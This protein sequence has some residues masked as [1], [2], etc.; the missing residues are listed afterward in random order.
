MRLSTRQEGVFAGEA[1]RINNYISALICCAP[2]Y[3]NAAGYN[4]SLI[5]AVRLTLQQNYSIAVAKQQIAASEGLAL[6]AKSAFDMQLQAGVNRQHSYSPTL[7]PATNDLTLLPSDATN[8]TLGASQKLRSGLTVAPSITVANARDNY[9]NSM[10]TSTSTVALNFT[11]PLLKGSGTTVNTANETAAL[12]AEK[13]AMETYRQ[14]LDSSIT[15][16]VSAYWDYL[17]AKKILDINIDAEERTKKLLAAAHE[18]ARG[19]EIPQAD[20]LQYEVSVAAAAE[21]RMAAEQ[22]LVEARSALAVAI[23]LSDEISALPQDDFPDMQYADMTLLGDPSAPAAFIDRAIQQ[24]FDM[25]ATQYNLRGA[26]AL[27]EAARNNNKPQ[28]DLT[29]SVGNSGL[30]HN[31]P[32]VDAFSALRNTRGINATIGLIYTSP[33]SDYENQGLIQQRLATVE[34]ARTQKHAL[35]N[36]IR[37]NIRVRFNALASNALRLKETRL[38][39]LT[40][41]KVFENEKMKRAH[42]MSTVL[43]LLLTQNQLTALQI[44]EINAQRNFAQA[45]IRFRFETGRLLEAN[46][47]AQSLTKSL[48]TTMPS[49]N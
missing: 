21:A 47:E 8:Y 27:L 4:G 45:L 26:E 43:D 7:S 42:D 5:D 25:Q 48:F 14:T 3:A 16:T 35:E 49:R 12:L 22:A 17:A 30:V 11:L 31:R 36:I 28:L 24:R 23:G 2:L 29:W 39:A 1:L 38:S 9:A 13:A 6:T 18:L 34:Q 44:S 20:V 37:T 40:Q 41:A 15:Q 19:D 32:A 10:V 33:I 46:K